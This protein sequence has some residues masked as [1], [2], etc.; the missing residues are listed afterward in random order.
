MNSRDRDLAANLVPPLPHLDLEHTVD[1]E[2]QPLP[3]FEKEIFYPPSRAVSVI[4]HVC[5]MSS[6]RAQGILSERQRPEPFLRA[7]H[8][9]LLIALTFISPAHPTALT[10]GDPCDSPSP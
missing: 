4:R 1:L 8:S 2:A 3:L 5:T 9:A 7:L 6:I 10:W